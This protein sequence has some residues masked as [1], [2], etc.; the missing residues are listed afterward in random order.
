[1]VFLLLVLAPSANA[2]T[3]TI[4]KDP[5]N[6]VVGESITFDANATSDCALAYTW[7][8]DSVAQPPSGSET[9]TTSFSTPGNHTVS[10]VA[11]ATAPPCGAAQSDAGTLT[12]SVLQGLSGS[13]AVSPDPRGPT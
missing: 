12:F 13:I 6:P 8:V 1:M 4:T 3:L 2:A 11:E 9:L 10:V 5:A 7:T